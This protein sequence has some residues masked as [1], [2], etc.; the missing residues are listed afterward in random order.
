M[1]LTY[2]ESVALFFLSA[3]TT[4]KAYQPGAVALV[5]EY[6]YAPFASVVMV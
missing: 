3:V 6:A 2:S 1:L 4:V 5:N